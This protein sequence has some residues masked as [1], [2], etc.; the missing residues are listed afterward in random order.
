M[1]ACCH[2]GR[3]NGWRY[4]FYNRSFV[5]ELQKGVKVQGQPGDRFKTQYF[6]TSNVVCDVTVSAIA[7]ERSIVIT[8]Q[9]EIQLCGQTDKIS[10]TEGWSLG[11]CDKPKRGGGMRGG[12]VN[13]SGV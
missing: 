3:T 4:W 13:V 10:S 7:P 6:L 12:C 9:T 11:Y 2:F 8:E 5:K 1:I